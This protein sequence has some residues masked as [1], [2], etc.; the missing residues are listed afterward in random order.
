M[1]EYE[2]RPHTTA[3]LVMG[4]ILI[5]DTVCGVVPSAS[6]LVRGMVATALVLTATACGDAGHDSGLPRVAASFSPIEQIVRAVGGDLVEVV[7]IV[8]PGEEAHEYEPT[9][10]Q[11]QGLDDARFVAFLGGGFQ[12]GVEKAIDAL[13][14]AVTRLDLADGL[15]VLT[16]DNGTADPHVWL[17]PANMMTMAERIARQLR[18]VADPA[19]IDRN[20]AAY[21]DRLGQLDRRFTDGLADCTSRALVTGHR[22]F[23]YLAAAYGLEQ[24]SVA[25]IS[26]SEEPSAA[27]LQQVAE[28]AASR[29][30]T[31]IFF[32]ENL[33]PALSQT[34][35]D[36]VGAT[37]AVLDPIESLSSEQMANGDDYVTLMDANLTALRKG[38]GCR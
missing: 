8:P 7:T 16:L 23:A 22:A 29:N 36:E 10:Q 13:P 5:R 24:I 2:P 4:M 31:T 21:R 15:E 34:V 9:A 28:L 35:A 19:T 33:P 37:T 38:L 30:V 11:L 1:D 20:L 17:D 32:E 18:T 25:G 12:S 3:S 6:V 27:T 14:T 26:P